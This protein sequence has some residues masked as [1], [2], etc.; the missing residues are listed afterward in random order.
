MLRNLFVHFL[1]EFR[2][3]Q[4]DKCTGRR[5]RSGR[6]STRSA[7]TRCAQIVA[8][9]FAVVP[10]RLVNLANAVL[11]SGTRMR[12][13]RRFLNSWMRSSLFCRPV[14]EFTAHLKQRRRLYQ[15]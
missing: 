5:G 4:I 1:T 11:D 3:M 14:I 9:K 12:K 10:K 6:E 7:F 15:K 8:G 2:K 13:A